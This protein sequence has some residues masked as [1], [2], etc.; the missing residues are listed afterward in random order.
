MRAFVFVAFWLV[1]VFVEFAEMA[2]DE[3]TEGGVLVTAV[4]TET[5][6]FAVAITAADVFAAEGGEGFL[7]EDVVE[8][9]GTAEAGF[10]G[11]LAVEGAFAAEGAF[12]ETL[13]GI[14]DGAFDEALEPAFDSAFAEAGLLAV[15][16]TVFDEVPLTF[17]F[18]STTTIS[19]PFAAV[20]EPATFTPCRGAGV[21]A[22]T[23]GVIR[24]GMGSSTGIGG[25][26]AGA[27]G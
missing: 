3:A 11:G 24:T 4:E 26:G 5:M 1:E 6:V 9:A 22:T 20:S 8:F 14:L 12:E 27:T 7:D 23:Q 16:V 15:L 21:G 17:I 25:G 2:V 18:V 19:L 10:D 13:D